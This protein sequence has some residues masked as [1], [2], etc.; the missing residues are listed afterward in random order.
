MSSPHAIRTRKTLL[1]YSGGYDLDDG[2]VEGI[3]VEQEHELV[4][5][6]LLRLQHKAAGKLGPLVLLGCAPE[7]RR[8][9]MRHLL[10]NISGQCFCNQC[11]YYFKGTP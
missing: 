8:S 4:V 1:W 10:V 2:G 9:G 3:E 11:W 5:Q 6:A 7:V